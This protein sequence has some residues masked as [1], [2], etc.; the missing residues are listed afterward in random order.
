MTDAVNVIT[1]RI[2]IILVE[3]PNETKYYYIYSE[4]N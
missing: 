4:N 1:L 2:Q 3:I